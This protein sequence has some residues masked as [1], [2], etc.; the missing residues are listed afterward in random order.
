MSIRPKNSGSAPQ[1]PPSAYASNFGPP[2]IAAQLPT[3]AGV[4][5]DLLGRD[6]YAPPPSG[7]GYTPSAAM[8]N[9]M[10]PMDPAAASMGGVAQPTVHFDDLSPTEQA[11]ATLGVQPDGL[12]PIGWL[13]DAHYNQLRNNNSLDPQFARRIEAYKVV[14]AV[15]AEQQAACGPPGAMAAPFV[16]GGYY[17]Q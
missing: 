17:A 14:S 12:K 13:N 4:N 3:N 8:I 11:A 10:A 6:P 1:P 2:P 9:A 15:S 7:A 16:P 5:H